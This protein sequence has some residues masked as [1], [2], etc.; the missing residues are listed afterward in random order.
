M[1]EIV[2]PDDLACSQLDQGHGEWHLAFGC[3]LER[4][5]RGLDIG[6]NLPAAAHGVYFKVEQ[7]QQS[8][9]CLPQRQVKISEEEGHGSEGKQQAEIQG[10]AWLDQPTEFLRIHKTHPPYKNQETWA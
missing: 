1:E 8:D 9:R 5:R 7:K 4:V 2:A 10:H 3:R 6:G